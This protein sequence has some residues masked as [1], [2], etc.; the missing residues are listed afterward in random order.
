[1]PKYIPKYIN[2]F[3][4]DDTQVLLDIDQKKFLDLDFL[5]NPKLIN[6]GN[7]PSNITILTKNQDLLYYLRQNGFL[8]ANSLVARIYSII[9][10]ARINDSTFGNLDSNNL[11]E[12]LQA[13]LDELIKKEALVKFN[14]ID[15]KNN[16]IQNLDNL[17]CKFITENKKARG[18]YFTLNHDAFVDALVF[19]RNFKFPKEDPT[20]L[21]PSYSQ[22]DQYGFL[23]TYKLNDSEYYCLKM[24]NAQMTSIH[25]IKKFLGHVSHFYDSNNEL[26][27]FI[28]KIESIDHT[29]F[30][31]HTLNYISNNKLRSLLLSSGVIA[32]LSYL[33][34]YI[35]Y[36]SI[37]SNIL[38]FGITISTTK[39]LTGLSI[40]ILPAVVNLL[41][42]LIDISIKC[43]T[44]IFHYIYNLEFLFSPEESLQEK[45]K[46]KLLEEQDKEIDQKIQKFSYQVGRSDKYQNIY[47]SK[48]LNLPIINSIVNILEQSVKRYN[49]WSISQSHINPIFWPIYVLAKF[50][51]N[52]MNLWM[53]NFFTVTNTLEGRTQEYFHTEREKAE[54][55][56]NSMKNNYLILKRNVN[57]TYSCLKKIN[58]QLDLYKTIN[59]SSL[60]LYLRTIAKNDPEQIKNKIFKSNN[61]IRDKEIFDIESFVYNT[62]YPEILFIPED[63]INNLSDDSK[64]IYDYRFYEY[65][66]E[67]IRLALDFA[68]DSIKLLCI[69]APLMLSSFAVNEIIIQL[70]VTMPFS[71]IINIFSCGLECF[72]Y[73]K[74]VNFLYNLECMMNTFAGDL[75][76][77]FK[78]NIA[79]VNDCLY[80]SETE[81]FIFK[82]NTI[83]NG[84]S[85][86]IT[87]LVLKDILFADNLEI[88]SEV[89][90]KLD[91]SIE[92]FNTVTKELN[93]FH[94]SVVNNKDLNLDLKV[95]E[96]L[97]QAKLLINDFNK[98][99]KELYE[100]RVNNQYIDISIKATY[101]KN[102]LEKIFQLSDYLDFINSNKDKPLDYII[103]SNVKFADKSAFKF[104]S[105][106]TKTMCS[107]YVI[108]H[109]LRDQDY[110]FNT[111]TTIKTFN[112]F[113]TKEDSFG[114]DKLFKIIQKIQVSGYEGDNTLYFQKKLKGIY[115]HEKCSSSIK[116]IIK[117]IYK[118]FLI[119]ESK[120]TGNDGIRNLNFLYN[121]GNELE[122]NFFAKSPHKTIPDSPS[123]D[124]D[125]PEPIQKKLSNFKIN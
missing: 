44:D 81:G 6:T 4:K 48:I 69:T 58:N 45:Q 8:S 101:M 51:N 12:N 75:R 82:D 83:V 39:I 34:L 67:S 71:L 22:D 36:F 66:V 68:L 125:D 112:D 55:E 70:F 79:K 53:N 85:N 27:E 41:L 7:L 108:S 91:R 96:Y 47:S 97:K 124:S 40:G 3:E 62:D 49:D 26:S 119:V 57:N 29:H 116:N 31:E 78:R 13:H 103:S 87:G 23:R 1:M 118:S 2:I 37:A 63:I 10:R 122:E 88:Q 28:N 64:L 35:G 61:H 93:Y 123:Y 52:P 95:S 111:D 54:K 14:D 56:T 110:N 18:N 43:I 121:F 38:L 77:F 76:I 15:A 86:S 74:A 46:F 90:L 20:K 5:D 115:K 92:I 16:L 117:K 59:I 102:I 21:H 9:S 33:P 94:K 114:I 19:V 104:L 50:T 109:L 30:I 72:E 11:I 89:F 107:Q 84:S 100:F 60:D 98:S 24:N 99:C 105:F 106:I 17:L 80:Q 25:N 42:E 65:F 32:T 120:R 113:I 73:S